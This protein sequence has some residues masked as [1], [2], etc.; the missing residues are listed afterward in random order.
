MNQLNQSNYDKFPTIKIDGYTCT[1]GWENITGKVLEACNKYQNE[2]V[3]IA[4]ECYP[5]VY[6][7]EIREQLQLHIPN[8]IL[9]DAS[10]AMQQNDEIEKMVYPFVTD[11]PVFGYMAPL[12]LTDFFDLGKV[13]SMQKKLN[14]AK[15]GICIVYG[16]GASLI[17]PKPNLLLYADMPRWEIQ[18]RFRNKS[19][20]N[21]GAQNQNVEFSYLYKRSFFVD[22]RVCD[23]HKKTLMN[24][25]DYVLDTTIPNNPKLIS[26]A[27]FKYAMT[28]TVSQPF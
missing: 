5:G 18:L 3:V 16:I 9:L 2:K 22:W 13:A 7:H 19:I 10:A 4:I 17:W 6:T 14:A 8:A 15:E 20:G 1:E 12:N 27:A 28:E 24:D 11:D 23:R 21:V 26:G 25:W